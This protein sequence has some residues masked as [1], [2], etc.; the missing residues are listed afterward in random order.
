MLSWQSKSD[1]GCFIK[2]PLSPVGL[3]STDMGFKR[4][5]TKK[6]LEEGIEQPNEKCLPHLTA[7]TLT[8]IAVCYDYLMDSKSY[9][10]KDG[11]HSEL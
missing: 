10:I 9:H 11:D 6:E 2:D 5:A 1:Y 4:R 8:V 3:I 7:V